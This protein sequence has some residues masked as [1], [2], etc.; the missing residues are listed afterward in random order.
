MMVITL[1]HD[2]AVLVQILILLLRQFSCA[3]DGDKTLITEVV[4]E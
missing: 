3:S 2:G 1:K 4:L